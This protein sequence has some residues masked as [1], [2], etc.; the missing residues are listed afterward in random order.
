VLL[1]VASLSAT[2]GRDYYRWIDERGNPVHS[3]RPPPMGVDYE[4]VS[5]GSGLMRQVNAEEG[6]VPAEVEPRVGNDFQQ[7]DAK[8]PKI[9]KNPAYCQ[10]AKDNLA[11]LDSAARIRIRNEKGEYR[12]ITEKEKAEERI[13]AQNSIKEHCE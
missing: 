6:A 1:T 10:R 13:N 4:V 8:P 11:T 3:D 2:A 7:I 5:T 9:E 12:Y